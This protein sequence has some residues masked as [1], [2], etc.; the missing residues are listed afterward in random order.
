MSAAAPVRRREGETVDLMAAMRER[1]AQ[2][3]RRRRPKSADVPGLETAPEEALPLEEL[4]R[5][6]REELPPAAHTHPEDD[7][8]VVKTGAAEDRI[9]VEAAQR[10]ARRT[11]ATQP[12][13]QTLPPEPTVTEPAV[14]QPAE[15][16]AEPAEALAEPAEPIAETSPP[17]EEPAEDDVTDVAPEEAAPEAESAGDEDDD[18][19]DDAPAVDAHV[20][21]RP[22]IL[23]DLLADAA[24]DEERSPAGSDAARATEP[25]HDDVIE[26]RT[27]AAAAAPAAPAPAPPAA[28]A[29]ASSKDRPRPGIPKPKPAARKSGRPGVPS[30]DDI[31]FGRKSD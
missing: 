10:Q 21:D 19:T 20:D 3:G 29:A 22:D 28:A 18:A 11:E 17:V 26:R 27:P 14:T 1:S 15:A 12:V 7:P 5:D 6:P 2:R 8:E 13:R 30:W 23:P 24:P 31:M 16:V 4:A 9:G 25:E